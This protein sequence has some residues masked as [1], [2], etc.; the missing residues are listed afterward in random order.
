[1]SKYFT[2]ITGG[3]S[4]IGRSLAIECAGRGHNLLIASLPGPELSQTALEISGK[5]NVEVYTFAVDLTAAD[6]P[7][8]VYEWCV[9]ENYAVSFLINNAGIAGA[10]LFEQSEPE[11]TDTR[12]LLNVRALALLTRYF[13][14]MLRQCPAA[15]ILNISSLSGYFSIPYKSIYSASK[16]FVISF[17]GSLALELAE[18]GIQVSV[19]CPNGVE[20]NVS[21]SA[22]INTHGLAGRLVKITSDRLA[23]ITMDKVERGQEVIIPLFVNRLLMVISRLLPQR[24][25]GR[26]LMRE[27]RNELR[28]RQS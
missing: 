13:L 9:R 14:P 25:T 28:Y 26:I 12:I 8:H 5:Y 24:L 27:F 10:A 7:L 19:V 16:A 21:S 23:K 3:S 1:M 6:G 15:R 2:L 18:T 22:R 17:S 11:Y 4:G 20:S